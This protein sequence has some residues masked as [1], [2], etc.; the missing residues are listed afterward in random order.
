MDTPFEKLEQVFYKQEQLSKDILF[1]IFDEAGIPKDNCWRSIY[2]MIFDT[3]INLN[4]KSERNITKSQL[5]PIME[6]A[7]KNAR[8]GTFTEKALLSLIENYNTLTCSVCHNKLTDVKNELNNSTDRF[9]SISLKRQK[10]IENLELE[11]VLTVESDHSI[12]EKIKLIKSKFKDTINLLQKDTAKLEK[13][14]NIDHLT[15]LYNRRFF[16]EQL[17]KE[18]IQALA[19]KTWLNLLIFDLDDFKRFND[20][21]GHLVGDQALKTIAKIVQIV[22][23]NESNRTGIEMLPTRYGGEEFAV[24][25]PALDKNE[26]L[27]IAEKIR[28]QINNYSFVIRNKEGK[29]KYQNLILTVSIGVA[30]LNH[31]YGQN[32]GIKDLIKNADAAMYE[33]KKAGKN[34]IKSNSE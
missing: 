23:H 15:S 24:I 18:V 21:Y 31:S 34:C 28:T 16:D 25:L 11:T 19:E 30:T 2:R 27:K 5:E 4:S 14:A 32:H 10:H 12:E 22:C 29:I 33:A 17:N 7:L 6:K 8:K 9:K 1:S 13:M 26:A 3:K 20:R